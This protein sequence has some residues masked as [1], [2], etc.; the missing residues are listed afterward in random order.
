MSQPNKGVRFRTF[1]SSELASISEVSAS[2]QRDWRR[3][4][5]ERKQR[6]PGWKR[7]SVQDV[8]FFLIVKLLTTRSVSPRVAAKLAK[9]AS[10]VV[11]EVLIKE[12][13]KAYSRS[14]RRTRRAELTDRFVVA[15]GSKWASTSDQKDPEVYGFA[16][17]ARLNAFLRSSPDAIALVVVDLKRVA[18]RILERVPSLITR[19]DK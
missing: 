4:G 14:K 13:S 15:A 6:R 17:I 18:D 16:S 3:R 10:S 12:E 7:Y 1:S 8:A 19:G 2:M 9:D 5:I 11:L